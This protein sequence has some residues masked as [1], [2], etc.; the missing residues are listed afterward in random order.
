[1]WDC[2]A[3]ECRGI[4]DLPINT[5]AYVYSF[6][7]SNASLKYPGYNTYVG[8]KHNTSFDHVS[9]VILEKFG[10][11]NDHCDLPFCGPSQKQEV[12]L[13]CS[14]RAA[15]KKTLA[16]YDSPKNERPPKRHL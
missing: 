10:A 14:K 5:L 8:T 2:G 1:M 11:T 3:T 15:T 7:E 9:S 4:Y 16:I 12:G 6:L 13:P